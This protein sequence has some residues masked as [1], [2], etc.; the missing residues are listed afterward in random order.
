MGTLADSDIQVGIHLGELAFEPA[1]V[2]LDALL[3]GLEREAEP[4][5]LLRE[6]PDDLA[7]PGDESIEGLSLFRAQFTDLGADTGREQR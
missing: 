6:H 2:L 5:L 7:A 3:N 1:N 4:V